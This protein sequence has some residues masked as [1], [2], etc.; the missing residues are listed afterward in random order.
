VTVCI[1]AVCEGGRA[2]VVAAD[3][4]VTYGPPMSLQIEPPIQKIKKLTETSVLLFSGSVPDG[5]D[6]A[7]RTLHAIKAVDRPQMAV[8]AELARQAY[9]DTKRKRVEDSILKPCLGVTFPAF[10]GMLVQASASQLLAQILGRP[11]NSEV[12]HADF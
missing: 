7:T 12:Q 4:M 1:G 5:E 9:E 3:R 10:Q 11:F 8:A 2:A 6:I